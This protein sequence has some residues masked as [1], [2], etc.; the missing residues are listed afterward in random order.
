KTQ[1]SATKSSVENRTWNVEVQ[2]KATA[3]A[4]RWVHDYKTYSSTI[5]TKQKTQWVAKVEKYAGQK[6]SCAITGAEPLR[7]SSANT[8]IFNNRN[9]SLKTYLLKNGCSTVQIN[10][11]ISKNIKIATRTKWKVEVSTSN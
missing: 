11:P 8:V 7:N 10:S 2:S 6:L 9:E 1:I 5:T 4:F 3:V